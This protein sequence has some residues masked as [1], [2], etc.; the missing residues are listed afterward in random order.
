MVVLMLCH[1]TY[2]TAGASLPVALS[3]CGPVALW[4]WGHAAFRPAELAAPG[5][6][7]IAALCNPRRS[8]RERNFASCEHTTS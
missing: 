4:P 3:P 6:A 2:A 8:V 5:C 7:P 1:I